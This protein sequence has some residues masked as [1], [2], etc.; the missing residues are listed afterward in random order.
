M[1]WEAPGTLPSG[2]PW[3]QAPALL[4]A[5]ISGSHRPGVHAGRGL[6]GLEVRPPAVASCDTHVSHSALTFLRRD[7][8]LAQCFLGAGACSLQEWRARWLRP[9]HPACPVTHLR[10]SPLPSP[11]SQGPGSAVRRSLRSVS[12]AQV[13]VHACVPVSLA[14]NGS[15]PAGRSRMRSTR[16][17]ADP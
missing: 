5:M 13:R 15:G 16:S 7:L 8:Y 3:V 4:A 2:D 14:S 10:A 11:S 6:N 9:G 12:Q 17:R 1:P